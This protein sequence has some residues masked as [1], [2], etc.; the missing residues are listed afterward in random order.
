MLTIAVDIVARHDP[1]QAHFFR[2]LKITCAN[3][4]FPDNT[5]ASVRAAHAIVVVG[6]CFSWFNSGC[7]KVLMLISAYEA[8]LCQHVS[9]T[10]EE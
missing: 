4:E 5:T 3:H 8:L 2:D 1:C 9:A 7:C 10:F 6:D